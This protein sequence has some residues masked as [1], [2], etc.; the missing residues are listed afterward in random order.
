MAETDE[1]YA[2][3]I[4]KVPGIFG[5]GDAVTAIGGLEQFGTSREEEARASGEEPAVDVQEKETQD[6][7]LGAAGA[8]ERSEQRGTQDEALGTQEGPAGGSEQSEV[9]EEADAQEGTQEETVGAQ[10]EVNIPYHQ[11]QEE[12]TQ[13][14]GAQEEKQF[15]NLTSSI[16]DEDESEI[17]EKEPERRRA[18][19]VVK[20]VSVANSVKEVD[21][22]VKDDERRTVTKAADKR[23]EDLT[24]E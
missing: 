14:L 16:F 11:V 12:D 15:G 8:P 17:V 5:D 20:D 18:E 10:E 3:R 6:E 4:N 13:E 7:P 9:P 22:L 2:S 23:R 19:D 1:E 24:Q 21:S